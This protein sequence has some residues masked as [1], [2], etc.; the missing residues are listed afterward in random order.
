MWGFSNL[1]LEQLRV[2]HTSIPTNPL[3]AEPLY[4]VKYIERMGTGT[5]DMIR[6]CGDAGLPEPE[7][8]DS[9]GFKVTIWR[10]NPK[11][12]PETQAHN[13]TSKALNLIADGPRQKSELSKSLGQK[14]ISGRLNKVVQHLLSDEMIEYTLPDKPTSRLQKY[15]LTEKGRT[16]LLNMKSMKE[17]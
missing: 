10:A 4:L 11:G 6:R 1:T 7:F 12:Q 17:D 15:R 16:E 8:D 9:S 14:R 13:L 5:L 2:A 3:L